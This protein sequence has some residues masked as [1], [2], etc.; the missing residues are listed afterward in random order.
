MLGAART[1][2]SAAAWNT[3]G[4]IDVSTTAVSSISAELGSSL[5]VRPSYYADYSASTAEY[6]GGPGLAS[7]GPNVAIDMSDVGTVS[8][9][10]V[11]ALTFKIGSNWLASGDTYQPAFSVTPQYNSEMLGINVWRSHSNGFQ[12]SY[13]GIGGGMN[14]TAATVDSFRNRWVTMLV[15]TSDSSSDFADWTAGP[16][17]SGYSW[18]A[19]FRLID[20]DTGTVIAENDAWSFRAQG[21][22]DLTQAWTLN[23]GSYSYSLTT[24]IQ[25]GANA[26][27]INILCFQHFIGSVVDI[28]HPEYYLALSGSAPVTTLGSN[29]AWA[30]LRF[31]GTGDQILNQYSEVNGYR[32]TNPAWSRQGSS[33]VVE[34]RGTS[35]STTPAQAPAMTSL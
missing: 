16:D 10:A 25:S 23:S 21:T 31:D 7:V 30:V 33:A 26:S 1:A 32:Y 2:W 34:A 5:L 22:I 8:R 18:A 27:D 4:N 11:D 28:G 14:L 3:G 29:R 35:F 13:S 20:V 19:R 6:P 9:R 15:A 12:F 17:W 24:S